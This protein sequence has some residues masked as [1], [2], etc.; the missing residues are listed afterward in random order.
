[1]FIRRGESNIA[2]LDPNIQIARTT[3]ATL[4][5]AF[6]PSDISSLQCWLRAQDESYSDGNFVGTATDQSGNSN[7]YTRTG[8]ERPVF[9]TSIVNGKSIYRFDGVNDRWLSGDYVSGFTAAEFFIVFKLNAD[10]PAAAGGLW[11]FGSSGDSS[12]IPHTDSN[13]YDAWM[14]TVR[15]STGDPSV[16][17]ST[18]FRLYNVISVSGEWTSNIDTT[19]HFTT[20][21]NTVGGASST[22]LGSSGSGHWLLGDIAEVCVFNAKL[23]SGDRS[24][25]ETYFDDEYALAY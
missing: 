11:E 19:E 24:S 2:V 13:V 23:S 1:V 14:S 10:P 17:L 18:A 8:N 20:A 16:D 9:K 6:S 21:T 22:Q 3:P 5:G 15:K 4:G 12:L 25:M 7:D